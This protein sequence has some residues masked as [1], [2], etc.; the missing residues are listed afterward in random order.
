VNE[1]LE[2]MLTSVSSYAA[3]TTARFIVPVTMLMI[4]LFANET[5]IAMGYAIRQADLL[6]YLLFCS[7]IVIP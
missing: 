7:V 4:S 5:K 6:Y 3:Q 2:A 1:G